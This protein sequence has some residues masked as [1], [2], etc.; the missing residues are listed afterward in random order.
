MFIYKQKDGKIS[1]FADGKFCCKVFKRITGLPH[2]KNNTDGKKEMQRYNNV[3][4]LTH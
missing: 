4:S 2:C 1:L 3:Q